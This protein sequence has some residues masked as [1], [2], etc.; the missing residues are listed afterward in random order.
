MLFSSSGSVNVRIVMVETTIV[1]HL[2][3][4]EQGHNH[5]IR[6]WRFLVSQYNKLVPLAEG[7]D[8]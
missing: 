1:A 2:H 6:R 5:S 7:V 3:P 8:E 4:R